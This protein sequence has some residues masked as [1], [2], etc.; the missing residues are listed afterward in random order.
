MPEQEYWPSRFQVSYP[1]MEDFEVLDIIIKRFYKSS[2]AFGF[3]VASEVKCEN[4]VAVPNELFAYAFVSAA[5]I[6]QTM[7]DEEDR[8][9]VS[10]FPVLAVQSD[11]AGALERDFSV[12]D[13]WNHYWSPGREGR[14][15]LALE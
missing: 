15:K 12:F 11:S 3:S 14:V 1:F 8:F 4:C 10:R 7:D 2:L 5:V 6:L 13:V 9:W